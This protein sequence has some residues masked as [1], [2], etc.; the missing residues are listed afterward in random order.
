V[1]CYKQGCYYIDN[2]IMKLTQLERTNLELNHKSYEFSM[3]IELPYTLKQF[4]DFYFVIPNEFGRRK[5]NPEST[6]AVLKILGL[7]FNTLT[8]HVVC[9]LNLQTTEVLMQ[10]RHD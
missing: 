5:Q 4:S 6:G 1:L 3:F 9:G 2:F 7:K 8:L 10:N